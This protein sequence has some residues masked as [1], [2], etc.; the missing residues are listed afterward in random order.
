MGN[1]GEKTLMTATPEQSK[2]TSDYP[3]VSCEEFD[4]M[5]AINPCGAGAASST[6]CAR[7]ASKEAAP[8]SAALH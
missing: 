4:Y 2:L 1:C 5:N 6:N 3:E 8:S 7:C